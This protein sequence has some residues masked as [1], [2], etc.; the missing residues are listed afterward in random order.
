LQRCFLRKSTSPNTHWWYH[1]KSERQCLKFDQTSKVFEVSV[2]ELAERDGFQRIGFE[3][4][5]GWH[6]LGLGAELHARVLQTRCQARAGYRRE[7][8]L[9]DRWQVEDWTA[10]ITGRLDGCVQNDDGSWLVEEFKSSYLPGS[11]SVMESHQRQ[12]QIYCLMWRRMGNSPVTGSLVYVDLATSEE[13]SVA[14]PCHEEALERELQSRLRE[15]LAIWR[16]EVKIREQKAAAAAIMPFPHA[17]PRPGQQQMIDAVGQSLH[18]GGHLMVE[19]PTGSGKTAASLYPA[20]QRGLAAGQQV[21]FLTSKTLQQKMAVS[22]FRAMNPTAR[23]A[24]HKSAPRKKCAPTTASSV[25]KIFALTPGIIRR[26]WKNRPP[27]PPA[28]KPF[29]FRSRRRFRRRQAGKSLP[30]RGAIGAGPARGC[31]WRTTITSSIPARH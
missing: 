28:R 21:V 13:F 6:R 11:G 24:R 18:S 30:V 15:L 17:S 10:L 5:E 4:G 19:A 8:H 2:R 20:L 26:K 29:P 12:L 31:H 27:G 14:V 3:R 7:V 16:A 9:Q 25:T 22:I 23:F 1:G